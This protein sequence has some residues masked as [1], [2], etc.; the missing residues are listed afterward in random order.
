MSVAFAISCIK[1]KDWKHLGK[2]AGL[3]IMAALLGIL[4]NAVTLFTTYE[5]AKKTIRGGS[6][7]ADSTTNVTKTGTE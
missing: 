2:S 1:A 3:G 7:L 6:V 4:V 5:Y